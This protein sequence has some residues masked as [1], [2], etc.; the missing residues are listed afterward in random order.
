MSI[1]RIV[2]IVFFSIYCRL[3]GMVPEV[4]NQFFVTERWLSWTTSF[5]IETLQLRLGTVHRSILSLT[6][7]YDFYDSDGKF[8][9]SARARFWALGTIFD[10]TDAEGRLIGNVREHLF[11]FFPTF[12]L[13]SLKGEVLAVA[14]QNL[15]ETTYYVNDPVTSQE[16]AQLSR[17][18][19][20]LKDNWSVTVTNP[21]LFQKKQIDPRFFIIVMAFQTDRDYWSRQKQE[22]SNP[23][24]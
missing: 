21:D 11:D 5:D 7:Q 3:S 10:V 18:F 6:T 20:R 4:P 2:L 17:S 9:A 16:I 22:Q 24:N 8:Q 1:F 23:E 19:F 15:W 13:L 12:D 14:K